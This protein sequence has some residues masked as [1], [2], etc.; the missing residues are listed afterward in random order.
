MF[1]EQLFGDDGPST[2]R[3]KQAGECYE[4]VDEYYGEITHHWTIVTKMLCLTSL[5]TLT[6]LCDELEFAP[7]TR[8]RT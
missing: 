5:G 4:K 6:E 8:K 2:T 3:P 7:N 1:D